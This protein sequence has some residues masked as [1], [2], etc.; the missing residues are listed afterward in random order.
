M[1]AC[2]G[3]RKTARWMH[4]ACLCGSPGWHE[5]GPGLARSNTPQ[6]PLAATASPFMPALHAHTHTPTH[7]YLHGTGDLMKRSEFEAKKAALADYRR[8]LADRRPLPLLGAG[9][10]LA[11]RP[12]LQVGR[13]GVL[14]SGCVVRACEMR[15]C[16]GDAAFAL[17]CGSL[18][19]PPLAASLSRLQPCR[20]LPA[21]P[22]AVAGAAEACWSSGMLSLPHHFPGLP[23]AG[24]RGPGAGAA[25]RVPGHYS[26]HPGPQRPGAGGVRLHRPG[27]QVRGECFE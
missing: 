16:S 17:L 1:K 6:S 3:G 26:L 2:R 10:A 18:S 19:L 4:E 13:V 21:A 24:G 27:A 8:G 20:P 7:R 11:G 14:W 12:L 9:K 5:A 22:A 25:R 15:V 23:T